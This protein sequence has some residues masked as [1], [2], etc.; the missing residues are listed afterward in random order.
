MWSLCLALLIGIP[1]EKIYS[2]KTKF[3]CTYKNVKYN[4][5]HILINTYELLKTSSLERT[6]LSV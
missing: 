2:S 3:I 4:Y 5:I 6:Q 1:F